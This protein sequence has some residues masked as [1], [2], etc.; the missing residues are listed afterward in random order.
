MCADHVILQT[1]PDRFPLVNYRLIQILTEHLYQS[2]VVD[3]AAFHGNGRKTFSSTKSTA[4][5][6]GLISSYI[7]IDAFSA[8]P[9]I[10][11]CDASRSKNGQVVKPTQRNTS[12]LR[13]ARVFTLA[14]TGTL[15][16]PHPDPGPAPCLVRGG[17]WQQHQLSCAS[18]QCWR[19]RNSSTARL[20]RHGA[21]L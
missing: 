17:D 11:G 21:S 20:E 12:R 14:T 10:D 8:G 2:P 5:S 6:Q 16:G 19:L 1:G 9:V 18:Y 4:S 15:R 7:C 3:R 13:I